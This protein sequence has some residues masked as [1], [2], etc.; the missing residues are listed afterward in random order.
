MTRCQVPRRS[1]VIAVPTAWRRA[2]KPRL[3]GHQ[4]AASRARRGVQ[5]R[6]RR[7]PRARSPGRRAWLVRS[8]TR[9][10][11]DRGDDGR[12]RALRRRV[13]LI[14]GD[15]HGGRGRAHMTVLRR[16]D[17]QSARASWGSRSGSHAH[18]SP[19]LTIVPLIIRRLRGSLL[20]IRGHAACVLTLVRRYRCRLERRPH[21]AR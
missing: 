10:C 5:G 4:C 9:R 11:V 7:R 12:S 1:D 8:P 18:L 19:V 6:R 15:Y 21:E 3:G 16:E 13:T 20:T 2:A 17:V 14:Y